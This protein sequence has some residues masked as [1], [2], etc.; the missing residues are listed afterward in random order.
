MR[1][2]RWALLAGLTGPASAASFD[3]AHARSSAERLICAD[4]VLGRADEAMAAAFRRAMAALSPAGRTALRDEQRM[5][6]ANEGECRPGGLA[7][8]GSGDDKPQTFGHCLQLALDRRSRKLDYAVTL[9]GGLRF[10][11][12]HPW[13]AKRAPPSDDGNLP[14]LMT[15]DVTL[16]RIDAP[17][18]AGERGWNAAIGRLV[19]QAQTDPNGFDDGGGPGSIS[20]GV[21][22]ASA[23]PE[24]ISAT[25]GTGTYFG[26]A[27][28]AYYRMTLTWSLSLNRPLAAADLFANPTSAALRRLVTEHYGVGPADGH[29]GC[30][31]PEV[32][33]SKFTVDRT[34]V[35]FQFD[36]YELGSYLC[37]GESRISWAALAP[38]LKRPL[39]FH[40]ERLEVPSPVEG[41]PA[42]R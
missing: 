11:T 3:C 29:E 26:G 18:S 20:I 41:A 12:L 5:F 36:P 15:E 27:H 14:P 38:F 9:A 10:L 32:K 6:V 19:M 33:R 37:G 40:P 30:D 28:P 24:L 31:A 34:G 35:V 16:V 23:S 1:C 25:V 8:L 22:V 39:P 4:P 42:G 2:W 13:R 17:R 21:D 7:Y